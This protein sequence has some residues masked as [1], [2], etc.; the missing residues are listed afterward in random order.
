MLDGVPPSD[1]H[2]SRTLQ[3]IG[4]AA[5]QRRGFDGRG[6]IIGFADY[7]FDLAHPCFRDPKTGDT[8][9]LH[10]IDQCAKPDHGSV[11]DPHANYYGRSRVIGGAHGT[12]MASIA[13]GSHVD[14]FAGVAPAAGLIGV[15]LNLPDHAWKEETEDGRPSWQDWIPEQVPEWNGWRSYADATPIVDALEEIYCRALAVRPSAIVINLSVGTWAG[16]HNGRSAVCRK[17]DEITARGE[18]GIGPPAIVVVG[19]GNAGADQGHVSAELARGEAAEINWRFAPEAASPEKLDL[20]FQAARGSPGLVEIIL[21]TTAHHGTRPHRFEL[22]PGQTR[23]LDIAGQRVGIAKWDAVSAGGF[24]QVRIAV[25][26]KS[27]E[28]YLARGSDGT[29][30]LNLRIQN[31]DASGALTF[32]AWRERSDDAHR[33][34][35]TGSTR[36]ATLC[37]FA[38]AELSL[39]AGGFATVEAATAVADFPPASAGPVAF[40]QSPRHARA[41]HLSAPAHNV[42]AARSKSSGF[43]K[44][45]G[46]SAATALVSGAA[47]LVYQRAASQG[48]RMSRRE[49]L[50]ELTGLHLDGLET[51]C[52]ALHWDPVLGYGPVAIKDVPPTK[53]QEIAT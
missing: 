43:M 31:G 42:S 1:G 29:R 28:R 37:D 49:L 51:D 12:A 19:A 38:C 26:P 21:S 18:E 30:Q 16:P 33:S 41:P 7:G 2:N 8:R 9:F 35:L 39:V 22:T 24:T 27:F 50:S 3:D 32:H 5:L 53:H 34:V 47:A 36:A 23:S 11:Y 25:C 48:R 6:V 10:L 14:G 46:T 44:T 40:P 4:A 52:S 17:I 13:A 15:H 20:W 45:S